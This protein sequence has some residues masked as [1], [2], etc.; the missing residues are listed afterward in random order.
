[1][2][3]KS[4][5][6]VIIWTLIGTT[7]PADERPSLNG[8]QA[9]P[10][11][12]HLRGPDLN[13]ISRETGLVSTW[14]EQGPPVLWTRTLGQGYSGMIAVGDRVYTQYQT[15]SGQYVVCLD[16]ETGKTVWE[17]R[18]APP[19]ETASLYPGPRGGTP[20]CDQGKIYSPLPRGSWRAS[21]PPPGD[22]SG[23]SK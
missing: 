19:Y 8:D 2:I 17:T 20:T 7:S 6:F 9:T 21:M 22:R 10:D 4:L 1:M 5:W 13:G 3:P 11:W 12:P 23:A 18:Y 14:S 16:A 15:L